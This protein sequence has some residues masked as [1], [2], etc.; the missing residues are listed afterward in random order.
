MLQRC[1]SQKNT[2]NAVIDWYLHNGWVGCGVRSAAHVP[3][4]ENSQVV[5]T[6]PGP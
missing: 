4:Y 2:E 5:M 3:R 6:V 1:V